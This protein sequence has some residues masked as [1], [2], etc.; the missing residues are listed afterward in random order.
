MRIGE[1][2]QRTGLSIS[3][4]R[5]YE[6]KGLIGPERNEQNRYREY[7]EE[8]VQQLEKIILYRKMDFTIETIA[9]LLDHKVDVQQAMELQIDHLE[10]QKQ[11]LQGSIDLCRK[12]VSDQ[13]FEDLD[14]AYYMNYVKEEE[15]AGRKF[16]EIGV[17]LEDFSECTKLELLLNDMGRM[18]LFANPRAR[19][20]IRFLWCAYLVLFPIVTIGLSCVGVMEWSVSRVLFCIFWLIMLIEKLRVAFLIKYSSV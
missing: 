20:A 7:E 18:K 13:A 6:K 17:F 11:K 15:S 3:N 14:V 9:E 1:V 5:F 16:A 4:I 19:M 8:D 2:A 10:E 12:I